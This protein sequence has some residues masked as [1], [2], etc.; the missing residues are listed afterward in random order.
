MFFVK[1]P[2]NPSSTELWQLFLGQH[3]RITGRNGVLPMDSL[4]NFKKKTNS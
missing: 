3:L 4:V 2:R 1:A